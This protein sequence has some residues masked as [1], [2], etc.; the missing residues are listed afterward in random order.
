MQSAL[1]I[2][3]NFMVI[4]YSTTARHLRHIMLE[5]HSSE[6]ATSAS[7]LEAHLQAAP[8]GFQK[9]TVLFSS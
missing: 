7:Q 4:L 5:L 9:M 6:A 3:A 1:D 8:V 2:W